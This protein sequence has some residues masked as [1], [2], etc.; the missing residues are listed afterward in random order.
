MSKEKIMISVIMPT[1]NTPIIMLSQAVESIL[2]QTYSN[3]E[4]IIID[5]CSTDNTLEYLNSLKDNRIRI[6]KNI[7]NLGITASLNIGLNLAKGKY[8]ARMDSDDISF[9]ERLARQLDYMEKHPE[10]V[11]CG[12]WIK[13]FGNSDY[14]STRHIPEQEYFRIS[15]LFGN[16]Y[17]LVHPTAFFRA[18]ILKNN[19]ILYDEKNLPTAQDYG[20]WVSCSKYGLIANVEE[21]LLNYRVHDKQISIAKK[22]LQQECSMYVQKQQLQNFF[23]NVDER[24]LQKHFKMCTENNITLETRKW[25]TLLIKINNEK[26]IYDLKIFEKFIDDFLCLKISNRAK[27]ISKFSDLYRLIFSTPILRQKIIWK[28]LFKRI[29]KNRRKYYES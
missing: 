17:G 9:P 16:M 27:V 21:I 20:M 26:K 25:F 14:I 6:I 7:K 1:Y 24:M 12:T 11:V 23:D 10:V 3:F 8:I 13:A 28:I 18:S 2:K 29:I 22:I 15:L 19:K 5:D 4:F